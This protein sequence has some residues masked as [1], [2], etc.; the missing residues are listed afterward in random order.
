MGGGKVEDETTELPSE[1]V[2]QQAIAYFKEQNARIDRRIDA[3]K[4]EGDACLRRI[5]AYLDG[6]DV[7]LF[8]DKSL[9][10]V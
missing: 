6:V 10:S 4:R 9:K 3:L 7:W 1:P 5:M 2:L 8:G